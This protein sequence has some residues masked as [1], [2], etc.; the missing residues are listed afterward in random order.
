MAA[1]LRTLIIACGGTG[2]KIARRCVQ[3]WQASPTG[4][5]RTVSIAVIDAHSLAPEGG[6]IL[7]FPFTA[8]KR[9]DYRA[10]HGRLM[11]DAE[12]LH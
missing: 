4:M 10:E 6:P 8:T 7:D 11:E 9:I 12:V 2:T 1:N 3:T 5:P